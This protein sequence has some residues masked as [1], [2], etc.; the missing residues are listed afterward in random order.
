MKKSAHSSSNISAAKTAK[1][2]EL[3]DSDN[4]KYQNMI[5]LDIIN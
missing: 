5:N 1:Q 4:R 2:A 3:E